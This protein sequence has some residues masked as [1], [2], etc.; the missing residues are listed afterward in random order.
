MEILFSIGHSPAKLQRGWFLGGMKV[1]T[2]DNS[3]WLQHPLNPLTHFSFQTKRS[4]TKIINGHKVYI[5]KIRPL[6]AAGFRPQTYMV[7]VDDVL[8]ASHSGY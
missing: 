6:V 3:L 2:S 8:V 7:Y 5:E 1:V 4:W